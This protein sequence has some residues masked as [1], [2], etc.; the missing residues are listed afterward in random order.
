MCEMSPDGMKVFPSGGSHSHE[1]GS[2]FQSSDLLLHANIALYCSAYANVPIKYEI[3]NGY[4][5]LK[6][7][8][9]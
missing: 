4:L 7:V 8:I 3:L 5:T 2:R 6:T 9:T 1:P